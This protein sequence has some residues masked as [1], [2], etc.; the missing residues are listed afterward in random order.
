RV[1]HVGQK[2]VWN[3][4]LLLRDD[5]PVDITVRHDNEPLWQKYLP[6]DA[7]V[8]VAGPQSSLVV[9]LYTDDFPTAAPPFSEALARVAPV[10]RPD[11]VFRITSG[12]PH[13]FS[14]TGLYL[15]QGDTTSG[16]G[17]AFR[18]YDDYP[19][20][21]RL[22]NLVDPLTYVCTRQEMERLKSSRG[23]KRQSDGTRLN[24]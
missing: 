2:Q 18:V 13:R 10:I 3:Y 4:P 5:H 1:I 24:I 6:A 19:K 9:S 15:I 11:S 8:S 21:T 7:L 16:K 22:E 12:Q 20:Y 17:I 23:A 14:A